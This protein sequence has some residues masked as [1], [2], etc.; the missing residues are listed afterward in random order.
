MIQFSDDPNADFDR[1]DAEQEKALEDLP[2]CTECGEHIQSDFAYRIS[3]EWYC[4]DCIENHYM[5]VS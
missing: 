5:E 2:L 3:G 4:E 1:Y